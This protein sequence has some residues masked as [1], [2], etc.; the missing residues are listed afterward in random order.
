LRL[1][2][3][4]SLKI[5]ILRLKAFFLKL[6]QIFHAKNMSSFKSKGKSSGF[7][8][9]PKNK[10]VVDIP[11]EAVD[12]QF[13]QLLRQTIATIVNTTPP[14]PKASTWECRYCN[15]PGTYCS[16]RI[17]SGLQTVA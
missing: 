17:D 6:T 11:A 1:N 7:F 13:I 2:V 12:S 14:S 15:I 10:F 4:L 3:I 9:C 5:I 16:A 8:C